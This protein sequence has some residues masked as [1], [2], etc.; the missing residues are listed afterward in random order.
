MEPGPPSL[1]SRRGR[2]PGSSPIRWGFGDFAWI[3]VAG[4]VGSGVFAAVAFAATGDT[5]DHYGAFT[6][7]MLVAGQYG[8]WFAAT[9]LVSH[10]KGLGALRRDFGFTV[11]VNR[12][13]ALLAGIATTL[14]LGVIVTPLVNLVHGE[15][16]NVVHDLAQSQG[17]KR[18]V[19]LLT[20]AIVAPVIEELLFR[21]LLL[22]SLRRRFSPAVAIIGSSLL[23]SVAHL[24]G[25]VTLGTVAVVPALFALGAIS[26]IA[27]VWTGDLSVSIPLHMGFNLLTVAQYAFLLHR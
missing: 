11:R 13:W 20:A 26:G 8:V 9:I 18:V 24:V 10:L 1:F 7:A 15:K 14:A 21:G 25:G 27:A 4:I 23:F 12:L 22:R 2:A 3:Y 6:L 16:E 5:G 19:F 17:A